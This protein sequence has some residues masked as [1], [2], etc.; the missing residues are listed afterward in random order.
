M[1]EKNLTGSIPDTRKEDLLLVCGYGSLPLELAKGAVA[2]GRK[3]FLVGIVGEAPPEIAQYPHEFLSWGQVGR[4]FSILKAKQIR[5]VVFAGGIHTRPDLLKLRLDWGAF[6]I[7]PE[8]LAFMLGGDNTVLSGLIKMFERRGISISG[9]HEIAPNLIAKKGLIAGPNPSAKD[10]ANI[11]LGFSACKALGSFDIGQAAVA[12][13]S[14]IVAVEAVE[15]TDALLARIVVMREIGRMPKI[16]R[17]GVLV[18]T[19]KPGQEMRADLPAIGPATVAGIV[20]AGLCGIA[21]EANHAL[22]L[23]RDNTLLAAREAGIFIY[24]YEQPGE[25]VPNG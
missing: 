20:A 24:G 14:R 19:M 17:N 1:P 13:A 21:I 12:E 3:P 10:F 25:G 8:A 9:A 16:G 5:E 4:L 11:K 6:K 18:K 2:S 22:I 15:G 7:L 23:E